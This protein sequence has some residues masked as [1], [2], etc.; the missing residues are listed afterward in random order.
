LFL[1]G[2]DSNISKT[3]IAEAVVKLVGNDLGSMSE[4]MIV[5]LETLNVSITE[6]ADVIANT[7]ISLVINESI[8]YAKGVE[9]YDRN[10][11]AS[12]LASKF[13][14]MATSELVSYLLDNIEEVDALS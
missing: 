13:K 5:L 3:A 14:A 8:R 9:F 4:D 1:P 2:D 7:Y 11:V 12:Q 6:H 10:A